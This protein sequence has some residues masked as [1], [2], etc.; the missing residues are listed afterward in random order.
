MRRNLLILTVAFVF[1]LPIVAAPHGRR[2]ADDGGGGGFSLVRTIF[3]YGFILQIA[4]IAT[5]AKRGGDRYWIWIIIIG[6]VIGA[7][8]YFLIEGMPDFN[9]I[10][11]S[12]GGPC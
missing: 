4:A 9:R 11:R 6:G 7:G 2:V 12:F 3:A 5:F 8:A 1:V 10:A